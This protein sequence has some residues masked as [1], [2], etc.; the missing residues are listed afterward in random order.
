MDGSRE[1]VSHPEPPQCGWLGRWGQRPASECAIFRYRKLDHDSVEK[2]KCSEGIG[3][4]AIPCQPIACSKIATHAGFPRPRPPPFSA[5]NVFQLR[6]SIAVEPNRGRRIRIENCFENQSGGFAVKGQSA[7]CHLIQHR[8]EGEQI[9][10]DIE[11]P[12]EPI[13]SSAR[14]PSHGFGPG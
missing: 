8:A 10:A 11:H 3:D 4:G 6:W 1:R 2:A 9:G 5:D 13:V 12:S 7:S 14:T